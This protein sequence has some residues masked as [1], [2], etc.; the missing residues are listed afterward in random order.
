V[1]VA[2]DGASLAG[3]RLG[4]PAPAAERRALV[5]RVLSGLPPSVGDEVRERVAR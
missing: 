1:L 2:A 3:A 4:T 5:E